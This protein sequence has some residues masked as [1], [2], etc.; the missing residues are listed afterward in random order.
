MILNHLKPLHR[1]KS[2]FKSKSNCDGSPYL[3]V[4]QSKNKNMFSVLVFEKRKE[5]GLFFCFAKL[6]YI[7]IFNA[8]F[9]VFGVVNDI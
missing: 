4:R 7:T 1:G 2:K 5:E 3:Y 8:L 9:R 6:L